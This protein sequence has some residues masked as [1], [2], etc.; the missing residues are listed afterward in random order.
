[1]SELRK[2]A[3]QLGPL[4]EPLIEQL[5]GDD[6]ER[7]A[8]NAEKEWHAE[9][10]DVVAERDSLRRQLRNIRAA[11]EELHRALYPGQYG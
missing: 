2:L 5:V 6:D 8:N 10:D 7:D 3:K 11:H 4:I 1:M 9:W